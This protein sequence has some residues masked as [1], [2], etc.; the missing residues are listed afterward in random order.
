MERSEC[1][2]LQLNRAMK[3]R[4]QDDS[5]VLC[6]E[7]PQEH[8]EINKRYWND[9]SGDDYDADQLERHRSEDATPAHQ[10][11]VTDIASS[12]RLVRISQGNG[13]NIS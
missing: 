4:T 10:E 9:D 7:V 2:E 13:P 12:R 1:S 8:R 3:N 6:R 11:R 5:D